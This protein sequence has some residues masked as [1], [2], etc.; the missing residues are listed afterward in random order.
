M[1]P[2]WNRRQETSIPRPSTLTEHPLLDRAEMSTK[3]YWL[4]GYPQNIMIQWIG[5]VEILQEKPIFHGKYHGF[6]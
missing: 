6:L 5:L 4:I 3:G 1:K 2:P